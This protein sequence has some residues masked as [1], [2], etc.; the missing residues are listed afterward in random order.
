MG[1]RTVGRYFI[2][3]G[4]SFHDRYPCDATPGFLDSLA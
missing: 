4:L 3:K 1:H 2:C